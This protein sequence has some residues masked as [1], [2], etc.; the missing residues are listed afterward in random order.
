MFNSNDNKGDDRFERFDKDA[1]LFNAICKLGESATGEMTAEGR[2][3][4][5]NQIMKMGR[6]EPDENEK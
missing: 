4:F 3:R 5:L 6:I 1:A 2:T